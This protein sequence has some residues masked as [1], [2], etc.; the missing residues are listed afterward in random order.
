MTEKPNKIY[1]TYKYDNDGQISINRVFIN[2]DNKLVQE[3]FDPKKHMPLFSEFFKDNGITG[4]DP[5]LQAEEKGIFARFDESELDKSTVDAFLGVEPSTPSVDAPV[6]VSDNDYALDDDE[7]YLADDELEE[8]N[9][10]LKRAGAFILGGAAAAGMLVGLHGCLQQ[11]VDEAK[12]EASDDIYKNMTEEQRE[13]FEDTFK[14]VEEFND[15][16][17]KEGNFKLDNDKSTLHLTVD[18]AVALRVMMNDYTADELYSIFGTLEFDTNN[19]MTLA[20]SAYSKLSTYYMNAKEP[21]GLAQLINDEDARAFFERHENAVIEFNNNPSTEL[22]D[23]VIKGMYYDYIHGGSTGE[24]AKINNDTVAWLA[25]STE[26]GFELANRNMPEYLKVNSVS[27]EEKEQYGDAVIEKGMKLSKITT[28]KLLTGINEEIDLDILDEVNQKSLC[29][30]VTTQTRDKVD[31]FKM[32]QQIAVTIAT[33][34]AKETLVEG[35]RNINANSLA[36]KVLASDTLSTELLDEI[37]AHNSSASNLVEDYNGRIASITDTEAKIVAALELAQEQFGLTSDIDLPDLINNRFRQKENVKTT[38]TTTTTKDKIPTV[39]KEVYDNVPDNKKEDFIKENG[40]VVSTTT[41][42]TQVE[43]KEEDLT[44]EEKKDAVDQKK[45]LKEI[46]DVSNQYREAGVK[47]AVAYTDDAGAYDFKNDDVTN[48][49]NKEKKNL[50]DMSLYNGVAHGTAFGNS[51]VQ[52]EV[53]AINSGSSQVQTSMD[54]Y[55][56]DERTQLRNLLSPEAQAYL[57]D[58]YGSDWLEEFMDQ[59]YEEA[60]ETQVD[61]SLNSARSMGAELKKSAKEAYDKAQKEVEAMNNQ[62]TTST[63][64]P[65]TTEK[66][67]TET[68]TTNTTTTEQTKTETT[69]PTTA[70]TNPTQPEVDPNLDPNYGQEDEI[71]YIAGGIEEPLYYMSDSEWEAAYGT[72][73]TSLGKTK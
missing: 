17:T 53:N 70:P 26:F 2:Y 15:K 69:T 20:R 44:P 24:Y 73:T 67:K 21:S 29:A 42:Q 55:S 49:Y 34:N 60:F 3:E 33:T 48:P 66:P 7:D 27:Q 57:K 16:A 59:T 51:D 37:R 64:T 1:F 35:L 45:V 11:Q 62:T 72:T 47:D 41:T 31:S 30:A 8:D 28:S 54:A 10:K 13:F 46:D 36:N 19:M 63:T 40:V 14:A 5:I 9:S 71:P 68:T 39:D 65:T 43:V 22:S 23:K 50:D 4:P 12:E 58:K 52:N 32:K 56:K 6:E 25:T 38:T 18:E 61:S